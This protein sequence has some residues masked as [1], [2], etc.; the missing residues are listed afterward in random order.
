M[1]KVEEAER[2]GME[3]AAKIAESHMAQC[4]DDK[5]VQKRWPEIKARNEVYAALIR[6]A[7]EKKP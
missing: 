6:A 3:R 2:R 1:D 7:L 5:D 4:L